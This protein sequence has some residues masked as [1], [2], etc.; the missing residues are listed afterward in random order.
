MPR[1]PELKQLEVVAGILRNGE[2]S[3]LITERMEDGPLHG[4]W[5]FPGGKIDTD[6]EPAAALI[7]E[8]REEIGV[9]V[10]ALAELVRLEHEYPDRSVAI[11]FFLID[12]W[13]GDPESREGQRLKW[14]SPAGLADENLLPAD[15][16]VIE[17]LERR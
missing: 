13:R 12:A 4:L 1:E 10:T 17:L 9:E 11:H 16:P 8:L 7:R 15:L 14:V 2:G 6:E 5:E 3:V